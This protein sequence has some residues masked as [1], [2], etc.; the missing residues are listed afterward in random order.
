MRVI[1]TTDRRVREDNTGSQKEWPSD[2]GA[3]SI[4]QA[5][6]NSGFPLTRPGWDFNTAEDKGH[7]KVYHQALLADLKGATQ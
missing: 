7:L 5:V 2:T 6:I 3:P 1:L 4:D